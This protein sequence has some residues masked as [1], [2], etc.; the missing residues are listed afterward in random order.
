MHYWVHRS[1][2]TWIDLLWSV[3]WYWSCSLILILP[4]ALFSD[5]SCAHLLVLWH[6]FFDLTLTGFVTLVLWS[7]LAH[8]Y[9]F[10]YIVSDL[11]L[12]YLQLDVLFIWAVLSSDLL[13]VLV[14][15]MSWVFSISKTWSYW[16]ILQIPSFWR[17]NTLAAK[18][19]NIDIESELDK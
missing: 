2:W 3:L 12:S 17:D 19:N 16:L 14:Y 4:G 13:F 10:C 7:A 9:C 18:K 8:T 6:L 5:F 11:H 1:W 15:T